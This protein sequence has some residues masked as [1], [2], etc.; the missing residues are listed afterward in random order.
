MNQSTILPDS[1]TSMW[2]NT[3]GLSVSLSV[4]LVVNIFNIPIFPTTLITLCLSAYAIPIIVLEW[5]VLKTFA[6]PSTGLNFFRTANSLDLK[7]IA[8]KL[9]G[10]YST[11]LSVGFIYWVFPHYAESIYHH[12][13]SFLK[14]VMPL[15][16]GLSV[17]YFILV[18]RYMIEPED[19]YW[20][21]GQ[22]CLFK[23]KAVSY[24]RLLQHALAWLVKL[25]F[26]PLMFTFYFDLV[27]FFQATSF[28]AAIISFG[29]FFDFAFKFLIYVDLLIGTVGYITTLRIFDSHVRTT[30]PS[31]L[32]WF[33]VLQCYPPFS[34][35]INGTY[36]AYASDNSWS[37]W[38]MHYPFIYQ[39]W[40]CLILALTTIYVWSS[41]PF[42]IRFSNL[43]HRGILTN[44]PYKY[45][46]HPAY[47]SKN[48]SWWLIS[49][50]FLSA[51]SP[52]V[53]IKHCLLLL[54]V[55]F[56]YFLRAKTEERHLSWD[57]DYVTYANYIEAN[58]TF[59]YI[60]RKLP[61][62]RF[63]K[64]RLVNLAD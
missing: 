2:I 43:T 20:E 11:L 59:S 30:E 4:I 42:G 31:F 9:L 45:C 19:V 25:F 41:L 39:I 51:V 22:L 26:L 5:R 36:L 21:M 15:I 16:V 12:Y 48:L 14:S 55:N 7:R 3:V 58:G 47:I 49:M 54:M 28:S 40:G 64:D 35:F 33:V 62:L 60:G 13:F 10:L 1:V 27:L 44:G 38:L 57:A 53:A 61:F 46:K 56:V 23:F 17:P 8:T 24:E 63:K 34:E 37:N 18:D 29:H 32:G 50:P 52:S 6:N